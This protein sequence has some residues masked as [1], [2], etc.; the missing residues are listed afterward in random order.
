MFSISCQN[1]KAMPMATQNN[2]QLLLL[3][4]VFYLLSQPTVQPTGVAVRGPS[5]AVVCGAGQRS[6]GQGGCIAIIC[7]AAQHL[8]N[9]HCVCD[10]DLL[11]PVNGQCV[12]PNLQL[13]NANGQC[14]TAAAFPSASPSA[15]ATPVCN[16]QCAH[17]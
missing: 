4:A 9:G 11:H 2:C 5:G 1:C 16:C 7:P 8:V 6:N 14:L 15:C 13:P 17:P 3:L 10:N 12:C